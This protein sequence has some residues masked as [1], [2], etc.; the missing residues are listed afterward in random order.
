MNA[1]L[2]K[3]IPRVLV[4]S[5][6]GFDLDQIFAAARGLIRKAFCRW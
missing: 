5:G 4:Y 3:P 6:H 1:A 2:A